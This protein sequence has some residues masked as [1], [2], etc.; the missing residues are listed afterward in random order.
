M[1]YSYPEFD[2]WVA[3]MERIRR[4]FAI[5]FSSCTVLDSGLW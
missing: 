1:I 4:R 5:S 3:W 2:A